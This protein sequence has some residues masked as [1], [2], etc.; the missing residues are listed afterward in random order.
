MRSILEGN[1][2]KLPKRCGVLGVYKS[3]TIPKGVF[4]YQLYKDTGIK[5]WHKNLHSSNYSCRISWD[6]KSKYSDLQTSLKP[7]FKFYPARHFKRTLAT[8][9][10]EDNYI[11]KYYDY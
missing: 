5:S 9:I 11:H 7:L 3:A 4:N 1:V 8:L 2:Y 6:V 10:K